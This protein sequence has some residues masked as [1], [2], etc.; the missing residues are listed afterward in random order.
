MFG[1]A[2]HIGTR[3][4]DNRPPGSFDPYSGTMAGNA[5]EDVLHHSSGIR[6]QPGGSTQGGIGPYQRTPANYAG[7]HGPH[8]NST[9]T[10]YAQK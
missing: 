5:D 1:D 3:P 4:L 2:S 8:P 10:L 7:G 9:I 6:N